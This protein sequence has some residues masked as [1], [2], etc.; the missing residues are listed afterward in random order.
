M[1]HNLSFGI[2]EYGGGDENIVYISSRTVNM[3]E[4]EN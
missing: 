2:S 1:F 4:H 3:I